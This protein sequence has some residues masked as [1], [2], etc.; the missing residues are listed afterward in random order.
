MA[1]AFNLWSNGTR[2]A[3]VKMR[4]FGLSCTALLGVVGKSDGMVEQGYKRST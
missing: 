4:G 3:H 2:Y 1:K